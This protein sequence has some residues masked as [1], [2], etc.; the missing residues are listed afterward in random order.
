[1]GRELS[2]DEVFGCSAEQQLHDP[3]K[4]LFVQSSSRDCW[5]LTQGH[6]S[7]TPC[8]EEPGC[9]GRQSRVPAEECGVLGAEPEGAEMGF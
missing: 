6:I 8:A 7:S 4:G 3:N 1:M 5:L 2:W 9:P